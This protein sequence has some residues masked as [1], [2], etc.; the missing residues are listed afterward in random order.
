MLTP[1]VGVEYFWV[2]LN[3]VEW[4]GDAYF[5]CRSSICKWSGVEWSVRDLDFK[6]MTSL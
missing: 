2:D 3:G 1:S 4:N 5:Q 6:S